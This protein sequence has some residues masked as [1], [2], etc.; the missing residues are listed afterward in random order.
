VQPNVAS[1]FEGVVARSL[2][3]L[4]FGPPGPVDRVVE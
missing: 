3:S 1:V 2:E 4:M